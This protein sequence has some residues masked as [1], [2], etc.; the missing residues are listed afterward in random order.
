MNVEMLAVGMFQ[1]NCFIAH[2]P[3]SRQGVLI[4]PGDEG[5]RILAF[6]ESN[7]IDIKAIINTHAHID[8]VSALASVADRLKAPVCMHKKDSFI[9]DNL[10]YQEQLF[11]L[12][13]PVDVKINEYLDEGSEIG[14]GEAILEVVHTPGHSPGSISLIAR[15]EKPQVVF[16]GDTLFR[17]SI[18]R[19]D[20]FGGD[21]EEISE[22][23]R[24]VFL[25]LPDDT[26]VY[27]GHGEATT[28]GEE[29]LHNPFLIQIR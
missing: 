21:F 22:T 29:K 2:C 3:A 11:R 20:L 28:I 26:I 8:H 24:N 27:P 15:H 1:S 14:F 4:D 19:T 9:F 12:P 10:A 13:A 23:L 25:E 6:I 18:G 7:E 5:G 16:S 17:G